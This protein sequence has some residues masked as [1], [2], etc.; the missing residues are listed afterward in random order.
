MRESKC[1]NELTC[2]FYTKKETIFPSNCTFFFCERNKNQALFLTQYSLHTFIII[3]HHAYT[4][5]MHL[6]IFFIW[7]MFILYVDTDTGMISIIGGF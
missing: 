4:C 5:T 1:E 7:I 3:M 2:V 6:I